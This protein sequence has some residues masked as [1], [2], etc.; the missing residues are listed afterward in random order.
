MVWQGTD[1]TLL[2]GGSKHMT[3]RSEVFCSRTIHFLAQD[4]FSWRLNC[5]VILANVFIVL[6]LARNW[7][8][9]V[10][11]FLLCGSSRCGIFLWVSN[12]IKHLKASSLYLS[13]WFNCFSLMWFFL[14]ALNFMTIEFLWFL[15][16]CLHDDLLVQ[17][18]KKAFVFLGFL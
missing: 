1:D 6:I 16:Y 12:Y 11:S 4:V 5:T 15:Y 8:A 7:R 10:P 2:N 3:W 13:S 9:P 18:V 17:K 14:I